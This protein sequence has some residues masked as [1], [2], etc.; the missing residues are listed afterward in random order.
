MGPPNKVGKLQLSCWRLVVTVTLPVITLASFLSE[1]QGA[2]GKSTDYLVQSLGSV[3][4]VLKDVSLPLGC[5]M[6]KL[7]PTKTAQDCGL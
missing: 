4:P 1:R 5:L 7:G 3:V 6:W 2:M